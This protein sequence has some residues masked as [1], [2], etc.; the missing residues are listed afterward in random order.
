MPVKVLSRMFRGKFLAALQCAY[1]QGRLN[2][3]G[4]TAALTDASRFAALKDTLYRQ[5]WVVYA[6]RPFGG[7][8]HV[9]RYLGRYSH[10]VAITNRRLVDMDDDHVRFRYKDYA[11]SSRYKTMNLSVDEFIRRFLLHVLPKRFVRIR[12][13]GLMASRHALTRLAHC[14]ELLQATNCT[15]KSNDAHPPAIDADPLQPQTP[16]EPDAIACPR[17]GGKLMRYELQPDRPNRCR[18]SIVDRVPVAIDDSS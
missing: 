10:R 5:S 4:S 9:F 8:D 11:N 6:K 18:S 7:A 1:E 2:F 12:H 13:Y 14:R 17:C 15:D 16:A 3:S